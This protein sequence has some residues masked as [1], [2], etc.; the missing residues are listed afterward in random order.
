M[1]EIQGAHE[2]I[3]TMR[4]LNGTV[5][6]LVRHYVEQRLLPYAESR[7]YLKSIE[8]N[9]GL[10]DQIHSVVI[11]KK[12]SKERVK[13]LVLLNEFSEEPEIKVLGY[14]NDIYL[15]ILSTE[16]KNIGC[17]KEEFEKFLDDYEK[18]FKQDA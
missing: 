11:S 10:E 16:I 18:N 4:N 7:G 8:T 12:G 6:F 2:L 13:I 3:K 5:N 14:R 9:A 1:A 17:P 15:P